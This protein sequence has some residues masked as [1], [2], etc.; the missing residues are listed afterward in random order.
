MVGILERNKIWDSY[1]NMEIDL[2]SSGKQWSHR[3]VY[4]GV[5]NNMNSYLCL[6]FTG[7]F[8]QQLN[9]GQVLL[10]AKYFLFVQDHI[11]IGSMTG[12]VQ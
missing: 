8:T 1:P 7:G 4:N 2:Q 12:Y 10:A 9:F 11:G 3:E 5:E 6:F